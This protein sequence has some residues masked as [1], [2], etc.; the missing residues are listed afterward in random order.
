MFSDFN[1]GAMEN[2]G[3]N[4]FNTKFVLANPRTATDVDYSGIEAELEGKVAEYDGYTAEA[5]ASAWRQT[6]SVLSQRSSAS[7][8]TQPEAG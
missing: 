5:R 3:L 6:E 7:C 1:M 8:S 2:K 4:I